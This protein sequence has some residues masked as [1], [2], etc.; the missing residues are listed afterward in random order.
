[1]NYWIAELTNIS[2]CH[3]PLMR[4]I[5][6]S[7]APAG[8]HTASTLYDLPGW[9]A[10]IFSNAWNFTAP[11]WSILW[12][13]HPTGGIWIATH[14]WDHYAFT[15]D[16]AF[17]ADHAYPVLKEAAEFFLP[18]LVEDPATGWLLGGPAISPETPFL[19]DGKAYTVCFTPTSDRILV[20]E[21]FSECIEA[22]K[23]LGVD[24]ALRQQWAEA[25]AK[26]P[27]FQI[28][29]HGQLQEW[30]E[31]Y[32]N[33][34]PH[35]R[36]TSHLLG[37]FPYAQITP[38]ATPELAAAVKVSIACRES[39]P[40]GYEEGSWGRNL[41]TLYHTRLRDAFAACASLNTLFQVEG[42]RS[43]MMG[44]KLAPR[45]AYEMDYNTGATAGIVEMLLQSHE[46][47]LHLLPTLPTVWPNGHVSGLC[48]RGGF[49]VDLTWQNGCLTKATI[50][51]KVGG[52]CRVRANVPLA[53]T[54]GGQPVAASQVASGI[55]EFV[56]HAGGE[57]LWHVR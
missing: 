17:L 53:F 38:E 18:Y 30:L 32:D 10:H 48:G 11:G 34:Q 21:L 28:G 5:E 49:V 2:E 45:N 25:R 12:G 4:W 8:R 47:Y 51:S 36:H 26:L 54:N 20:Y 41:L 55:I 52:P 50:Y 44:T 43:L 40:G 23:V 9:I 46:G 24:E 57:Y 14:L 27:P 31:D 39:A 56:T 33:A 22:S 15:G 16:R 7:L 13:M 19:L 42:D 29:K 1:M 37:V 3:A 35:H 6:Q